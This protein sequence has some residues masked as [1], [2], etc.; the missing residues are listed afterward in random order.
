MFCRCTDV[1]SGGHHIRDIKYGLDFSYRTSDLFHRMFFFPASGPTLLSA[2][3][4]LYQVVGVHP[5][6]DDPAGGIFAGNWP[7]LSDQRP[8]PC[9][10]EGGKVNFAPAVVTSIVVSIWQVFMHLP[11]RVGHPEHCLSPDTFQ[12]PEGDA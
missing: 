1:C 3:L 5:P 12:K 7:Y 10:C 11:S 8:Y 6:H 2:G 4:C 9:T